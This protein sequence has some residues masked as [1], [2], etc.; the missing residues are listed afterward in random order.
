MGE[1]A[2]DGATDQPTV[3]E[4]VQLHQQLEIDVLALRRLAVRVSHMV[5]VKINTCP[6][7][8]ALVSIA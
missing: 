2:T 6:Q 4:A 1:A 5:V 7:R 8:S 3:Q